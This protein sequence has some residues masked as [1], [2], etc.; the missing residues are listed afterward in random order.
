MAQ[1]LF[2]VISVD[3]GNLP[4]GIYNSFVEAKSYV[5]ELEANGKHGCICRYVLNQKAVQGVVENIY[6]NKVI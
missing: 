2:V 1:E 3:Y 5:D 6:D 4:L